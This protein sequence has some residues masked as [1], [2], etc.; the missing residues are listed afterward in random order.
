MYFFRTDAIYVE[1]RSR[2]RRY[3][4]SSTDDGYLQNNDYF[5]IKVFFSNAATLY[6]GYVPSFISLVL[7]KRL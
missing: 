3:S 7:I 1:R 5:I 2:E 6:L 4:S